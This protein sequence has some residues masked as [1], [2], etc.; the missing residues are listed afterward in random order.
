MSGTRATQRIIVF[1]MN[2][3]GDVLF[4]TPALA[5]LRKG[6][7]EA[8]VTVV[9]G[10]RAKEVLAGNPDVDRV[11]EFPGSLAERWSLL[12]RLRRP[13]IDASLSLSPRNVERAVWGVAL[14]CRQRW[15][16]ARPETRVFFT[17]R[18]R[19]N[20]GRHWAEDYLELALLAGG[21]PDGNLPRL[22]LTPAEE[23]W[24]EEFPARWGVDTGRMRVGVHIGASYP[25]KAWRRERFLDFTRLAEEAC[26]AQVI[27][28]GG[29][30]EEAAT[31]DWLAER[32]PN[33]LNL[34]GKLSLREFAAAVTRCSAFVGGDS[35]PTHIAAALGV[36]TVALYG[37][38]DPVRMGPLGERV[39]VLLGK[40]RNWDPDAQRRQESPYQWLDPIAPEE[41][42]D[43]VCRLSTC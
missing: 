25:E 39:V 35:G 10:R 38:T 28:F 30:G 24:A 3:I 41:V 27:A 23:S 13:R 9:V 15:G 37:F 6:H 12:R 34:A 32:A 43:A 42:W 19:E 22:R 26:G 33:A 1:N 8:E 40:E 4:T 11:L 2:F 5:A 17:G 16:F 14:G 29:P 18:M 7:P 36:P 20:Q 31:G 21:K